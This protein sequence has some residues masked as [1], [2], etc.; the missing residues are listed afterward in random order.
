[1]FKKLYSSLK[2]TANIRKIRYHLYKRRLKACGNRVIFAMGVKFFNPKNIVIGENVRIGARSIL[3]GQGGITIGSNV[4]LGTEVIIWS[5]NHNYMQ[6][7]ELPYDN[8]Y[9]KR[10]V[11]IEDNVW[12]GAR[13]SI[14]PGVKIEE[15]AVIGL[16]AVVTRDVPKCAVVAGNPAKIIKYRNIE[17]Y[18]K[19][20]SENSFHNV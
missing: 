10:P 15:G 3:S 12:L 20:K 17:A 19:L 4:S 6:P 18:E 16:G 8:E 5:A 11:I 1:M 9:I 7:K 2:V 14:V 13:S